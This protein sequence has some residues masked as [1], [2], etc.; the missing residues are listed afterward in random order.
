M[1]KKWHILSSDSHLIDH[2]TASLKCSPVIATILANRGIDSSA[3]G[4]KFLNPSL[5]HLRPPFSIK[6][7]DKGINRLASAIVNR[8]NILVFGD[9][10]VDGVTATVLLYEFLR[11]LGASV[12]YYIPHRTTEG[13]GLQYHHI[14]DIAL[15]RKIDLV[16]T[17]DCGTSSH[18]A[19]YAAE[20]NGIDVV[21]TDHHNVPEILPKAIAVINPKRRDCGAGFEHLSGVGVAFNL[22]ICLRKHLRKMDFWKDRS[23]PNLKQLTDLVALGTIADQVPLVKENRILTKIGLEQINA[24]NRPGIL[25]L[26]RVSGANRVENTEDIAYRLAPRLN[27]AGRMAHAEKAASL[28][29]ANDAQ[30]AWQMAETLNDLNATRRNIEKKLLKEIEDYIVNY[31]ELLKKNSIVLSNPSWHEGILGI[32]ASR[33]VDT[34]FSPVVLI[35]IKDGIGKGSARGMQGLDLYQAIKS[36]EITLESFGGHAM[37]AGIKVRE[38]KIS[39]FT[40]AFESAV[41]QQMKTENIHPTLTIDRELEFSRIAPGLLDALESLGPF[42]PENPEPLFMSRNIKIASQKIVGKKHRQ[43]LLEQRDEQATK[44]FPAIQFNIDPDHL[45]DNGLDSLINRI[46]FRLRWNRWNDNKRIQLVVEDTE[47]FA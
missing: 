29:M 41:T 44:R 14:P 21:V 40:T 7:M 31:P 35:T 46:A 30:T 11:A 37:A 15:P 45:P 25:A 13:Y 36:C 6:D 26:V 38:D 16:I 9:Y 43:L 10:D 2:L 12:S 4:S 8:E 1:K 42:G 19:I 22:L 27:A 24:G 5:G 47:Y 39:L 3:A 33:M 17:A 32:V 28:L 23:E 34:Y 18:D 20:Q